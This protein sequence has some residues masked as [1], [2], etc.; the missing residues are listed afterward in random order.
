MPTLVRS[1]I[2]PHEQRAAHQPGR[3]SNMREVDYCDF[4]AAEYGIK[5]FVHRTLVHH[6]HTAKFGEQIVNF[7]AKGVKPII[8]MS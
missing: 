7:L 3:D 6:R 2:I 4:V 5:D 1:G 8:L